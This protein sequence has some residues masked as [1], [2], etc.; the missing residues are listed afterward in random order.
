MDITP[1]EIS[2]CVG[3]FDTFHCAAFQNEITDCEREVQ[4]SFTPPT[5]TDPSG[6]R[7][8][9]SH[10]GQD[11]RVSVPV[12]G[13]TYV[14]YSFTDNADNV[15]WC[16]FAVYAYG[17]CLDIIL[18]GILLSLPCIGSSITK[19][20]HETQQTKFQSESDPISNCFTIDVCK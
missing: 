7:R 16:V 8:V 19:I 11:G 12:D 17:K 18:E 6:I 2:G 20:N 15:A 9:T 13:A 14:E 5:A 10:V 1:P 3:I 4:V